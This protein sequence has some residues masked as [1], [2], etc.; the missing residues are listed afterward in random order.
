MGRKSR[1]KAERRQ[2]MAGPQDQL[3]A[4]RPKG[5]TSLNLTQKT[6]F[7]PTPPPEHVEAYERIVPGAAER[8]LNF[9]E[10]EMRHRRQ[11][12]N[13]QLETAVM[14]ANASLEQSKRGQNYAFLIAVIGILGTLYL[15]HVGATVVGSVL[16]GGSLVTIIVAFLRAP[17]KTSPPAEN[18]EQ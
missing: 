13:R 15:G 16:G 6:Y 7:G 17:S 18:P 3:P 5:S 14:M 4:S 11:L 1:L 10:D 12:E 8:F 9:A 2:L